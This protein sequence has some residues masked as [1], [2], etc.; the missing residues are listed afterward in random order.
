DVSSF[1]RMAAGMWRAPSDPSIYGQM[2]VDATAA[3]AFLREHQTADTRLT[4]THLVARAVAVALRDQPELN[5]KIRFGGRLEQRSTVDVFVT[6]ATEGNKDLS[7][8]RIER[9]DEKPL[10]EL[11]RELRDRVS[12]IRSGKDA[13]Y[14]KS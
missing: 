11:A 10:L 14:K 4:V 1:R 3:L 8:A 7:G 6:V 12:K 5:A 2:D 9:A 13:S